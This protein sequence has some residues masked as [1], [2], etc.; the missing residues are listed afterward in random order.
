[1]ERISGGDGRHAGNPLRNNS[2][3]KLPGGAGKKIRIATTPLS[4]AAKD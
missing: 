4:A 3:E 1:V 2:S